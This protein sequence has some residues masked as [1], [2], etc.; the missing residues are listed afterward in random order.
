MSTEPETEVS[1]SVRRGFIV[2]FTAMMLVFG[3]MG[4]QLDANQ[5]EMARA[6]DRDRAESL[7]VCTVTNRNAVRLNRF[8]DTV[9]ESVKASPTLNEQEKAERIKAYASIKASVPVCKPTQPT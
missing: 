4:W 3:A 7:K 1:H 9:I 6:A 8:L 5:R 2:M